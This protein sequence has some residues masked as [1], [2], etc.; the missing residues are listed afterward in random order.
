MILRIRYENEVRSIELDAEATEGLWV[1]LDLETDEEITQPEREKRIQ[2]AF[3]EQFNKPEYNCWHKFNRH[4]GYSRAQPGK[5]DTEEDVDTSEPLMSEV[6][7]ERIFLRDEIAREEKEEYE[8]VCQW[9]REI[10]VKKPKWA[11]AF[12]AVR[13]DGVSV[14]DYAASIGVADASVVSK[15]LTRATK[16]L[17]ENWKKRQI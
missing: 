1:S 7:D 11:D 15:W 14:N 16:K 3:D 10:L 17:K 13:I 9:I 8:A 5:D 6:R 4:R 2:A 12:I